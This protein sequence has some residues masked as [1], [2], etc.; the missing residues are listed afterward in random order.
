MADEKTTREMTEEFGWGLQVD[1]DTLETGWVKVRRGS[2][3]QYMAV[4]Y[5]GDATWNNDIE[6]CQALRG[7]D[8]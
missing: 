1:D 4:A 8:G 3:G 2:S 7:S 6:T 5:G